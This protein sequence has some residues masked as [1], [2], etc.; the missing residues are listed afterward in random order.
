MIG[1]STARGEGPVV[2]A[3]DDIPVKK[4]PGQETGRGVQST[5]TAPGGDRVRGDLGTILRSP[6]VV[7]NQPLSFDGPTSGRPFQTQR[8]RPGPDISASVVEKEAKWMTSL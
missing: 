3:I 7:E 5:V 8:L 1:Q 2:A 6:N 4:S